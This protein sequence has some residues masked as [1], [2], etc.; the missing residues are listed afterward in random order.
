MKNLLALCAVA[1]LAACAHGKTA[2]FPA[3]A[4]PA[5]AAQVYV[6]RNDNLLGW[7]L[8]VAVTLNE[9][10]IAHLRAGEHIALR[11]PP[12]LYSVGITESSTSAAFEKGRKYYFLVSADYTPTGFEI[13]SIVA[14]RGEEWL[15]KTKLL[16]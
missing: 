3:T 13:E 8:S 16:P 5:D 14:S 11:L 15:S 2:D 12:G 4:D 9:V 6:I 7:G 1:L 10:P